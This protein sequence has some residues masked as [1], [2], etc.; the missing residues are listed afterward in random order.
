MGR[1]VS[2]CINYTEEESLV[3]I[4]PL[5]YC[6]LLNLDSFFFFFFFQARSRRG[7]FLSRK[8]IFTRGNF[9]NEIYRFGVISA[10]LVCLIS[11]SFEFSKAI[12][13]C[14]MKTLYYRFVTNRS[15]ILLYIYIYI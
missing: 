8:S 1:G 10:V 13:Y 11:R 14:K 5:T 7:R 9:F 6:L 12:N 3:G 15:L 4:V 2:S